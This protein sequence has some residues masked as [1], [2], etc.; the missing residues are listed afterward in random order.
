MCRV[1]FVL[2]A[3]VIAGVPD[4]PRADDEIGFTSTAWNAVGRNDGIKIEAF[5]DEDIPGVS[6]WVSRAVKG[7]VKG[8]LGLAEDVSNAAIACRQT[9]PIDL[10]A[11]KDVHDDQGD[12]GDQVFRRRLN[13]F[14]KALKV[15]RFIDIKRRTIVY[16]VYSEKL[17]DGSP[18]NVL[19][20][21]TVRN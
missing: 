14:T 17:I 16:L 2:A 10:A 15:N 8:G 21:V 11:L 6:C 9:G 5:D 19:S 7:G 13:V 4:R 18:K 3:L 12:E 20:V 1:L